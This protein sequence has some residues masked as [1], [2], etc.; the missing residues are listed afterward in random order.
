L[1]AAVAADSPKHVQRLV[2]LEPG[3]GVPPA[4]ALRSAEIDRL[5]WN[6]ATVD[7]AVNALLSA[8]SIVA[9]P[10]QVVEEFVKADVRRGADG[11]YR[12]RFCPSA[13]VVAWSEVALAPPPIAQLPTLF[14]RAQVPM[15][16]LAGVERRYQE[17]LG[18]LLTT[19]SVPNGHNVLWESPDQTGQ[20]IEAFLA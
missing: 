5:D 9:A 2:L 19:L 1:A 16:D 7:G 4:R 15:F 3:L 10:H 20:A 17:A 12:F 6:F 14:V 18:D 11:R 13:A 8:D